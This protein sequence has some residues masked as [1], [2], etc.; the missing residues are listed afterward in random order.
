MPTERSNPEL[1]ESCPICGM[2][3]LRDPS[4]GQLEPCAS[5]STGERRMP[6]L[7][8]IALILGGVLLV[9]LLVAFSIQ[10]LA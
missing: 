7:L 10:L 4:S 3:L 2:K 5:C 6:L 1:W 9:V 8:G